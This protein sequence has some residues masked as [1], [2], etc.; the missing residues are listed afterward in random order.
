MFA[1]PTE[2][3]YQGKWPNPAN[4]SGQQDDADKQLEGLNPCFVEHLRHSIK[5]VGISAHEGDRGAAV[6]SRTRQLDG[7]VVD[8]AY[9]RALGQHPKLI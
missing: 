8:D 3:E 6:M 2:Y 9:E 7:L 5:P 4:L 1:K